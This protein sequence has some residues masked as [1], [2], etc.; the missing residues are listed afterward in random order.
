VPANAPALAGMDRATKIIVVCWACAAL[1]AELLLLTRDW[2]ALLLTAGVLFAAGAALSFVNP[3]TVGMVLAFTYLVPVLTWKSHGGYIAQF[4]A[5]WIAGLLGVMVPDGIRRSWNIPGVWRAPLV[6]WALTIAVGATMVSG[7]EIDFNLSLLNDAR[8]A[9]SMTGGTPAF[10]VSW[11]LHVALVLVVGI[12]WFDWLFGSDVDFLTWIIAPLG[13]SFAL[14]A[15]VSIYQLFHDP[16]FLNPTVFGGTG[17]ASGTVLDANVCGTLAALWIGGSVL[18]AGRLKQGGRL[19]LAVGVTAGWLTVWATGSRTA[20]AAAAIVTGFSLAAVGVRGGTVRRHLTAGRV[21]LFGGALTAVV[22]VLVIGNL[23]VV[24][25]LRRFQHTLPQWSS[26]SVRAFVA[27]QLWIRNGYGSTA[28][29]MIAESPMVGFGP[30]MFH[31]LVSQYGARLSAGVPLPPDNAQ[32]WFRHQVVEFGLLGSL[33]WIAWVGA[34]GWFVLRR[35]APAAAWPGR[36]M[37][38]AFAVISLVGMPAQDVFVTMT[39]WTFA[40]WYVSL[41]GGGTRGSPSSWRSWIVIAIL[42]AAFGAGTIN[43]AVG[44]LRVARRAQRVG[45]P[46]S[47]GFYEPEPDGAGGEFRW[48]RGR[49][50]A[51]LD[52][53]T[54]WLALTVSANQPDVGIRP[55]DVKVWRDGHIALKAHLTSTEPLTGYVWIP[56]AERRVIIETWVSRVFHVAADDRTLGLRVKWD[57]VTAPPPGAVTAE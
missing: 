52:A 56:F 12:L 16:L 25:P 33:G 21:W 2:P 20:F 54:R 29:A 44:R 28:S 57:F 48:A 8:I 34:F 53:P 50:V 42:V 27:E 46:Y 17:R 13:A 26:A 23:R 51:V 7:R 39:F 6:C 38:V 11:V 55:V 30:G 14:M 32:N 36:G 35:S 5:L 1:L 47:Y 10:V 4:D 37:L 15:A 24:G 3:R 31:A 43:L 41:V 9:N 19:V 18:A 22:L 40:F 49:A 45:W